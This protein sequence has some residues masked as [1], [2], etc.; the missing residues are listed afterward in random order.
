LVHY[1]KEGQAAD[2]DH[3]VNHSPRRGQGAASMIMSSAGMDRIE[4]G[5]IMSTYRVESRL[6]TGHYVVEA[7]NVEQAVEAAYGDFMSRHWQADHVKG[8]LF[9]RLTNGT[10]FVSFVAHAYGMAVYRGMARV[11]E[12]V[13]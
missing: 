12:V 4:G 7:T 10:V 1:V 8:E 6:L 3:Y 5:T 9:M 11:E 2:V 13:H